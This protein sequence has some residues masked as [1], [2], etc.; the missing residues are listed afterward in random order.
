MKKSILLIITVL[1]LLIG[2]FYTL[3]AY[4]C[5]H[6]YYGWGPFTSCSDGQGKGLNLLGIGAN[7]GLVFWAMLTTLLPVGY[8]YFAKRISLNKLVWLFVGGATLYIVGFTMI[9]DALISPGALI[10]IFN[11]IVIFALLLFFLVSMTTLGNFVFKKLTWHAW[12]SMHDVFLQFTVGLIGFCVLNVLLLMLNVY[13]GIVIR[14]QV[15]ALAYLLWKK[16]SFVRHMLKTTENFVQ[17]V[18]NIL[19]ALPWVSIL[20]YILIIVTCIYIYM[21]LNLSYIP[22][23]TAWDANHAYIFTPRAWA[24][25]NGMYWGASGATSMPYLWYGFLA[26]WFKLAQ[27]VPFWHQLFGISPDALTIIMNFWSGP[28]VLFASGFLLHSFI[29]YL[30]EKKDHTNANTAYTMTILC[31]WRIMMILWLT[32]GMGAFLVFVDNKTDLAVMFLSVIALY[33]GIQFMRSLAHTT[34]NEEIH[35][36]QMHKGRITQY[37]ILAW[38]FFAASI[39]AKPTGMFDMIHFGILFL[40]Q[41]QVVLFGVGA[42]IFILWLLWKTQLLLIS[43]FLT[44]VQSTYLLVIGAIITA[45]WIFLSLKK[46]SYRHYLRYFLIWVTTIVASLVLYK[47]PYTI[48]QQIKMDGHVSIPQ[49][50]RTIV[51][52]Y[53]TDEKLSPASENTTHT[54]SL[55]VLLAATASMETLQA[56]DAA[57]TAALA[58]D[59]SE[60]STTW[61]QTMSTGITTTAM[62]VQILSKQQCVAQTI[63]TKSLYENT[64]KYKSDGGSE[65]LGRYVGY[66]WKG[67]KSI[68]VIWRLPQGC[69]SIY[70]D[71]Q[72]LCTNYD[73]VKK[74]DFTEI[75]KLLA[76]LPQNDR[77]NTWIQKWKEIWDDAFARQTLVKEIT[78]YVESNAIL[79]TGETTNVPYKLL[80]PLNVTFN[81]SLQNLS[82][83]YTDIGIIW[84]LGLWLVILGLVYGLVTRKKKLISISVITL[85]AWATWWVIASGIIWYSLGLIVWT[86][87][88]TIAYFYYVFQERTEKNVLHT[89]LLYMTASLFVLWALIQLLLNLVRISSQGGGGPFVRYKSNVWQISVVD[90]ELQPQTKNVIGYGAKEVLD[91]QFPHYN[92]FLNKVN[93]RAEWEGVII[94]GTY[95]QYFVNNQRNVVADGFLTLFWENLSDN[96][97]CNTYLRLKDQKTK[98]I[99]IDPNIA[100]VVMGGGNSTLLDRFLWVVWDNGRIAQ[101]GTLTMLQSLVRNNYLSLFSTNNIVTKYAFTATDDQLSTLLKIPVG[102]QLLVE[103]AKMSSARYFPNSQAYA[104]AAADLFVSRM[105]TYEAMQDIADI[106]GKEIRA[107]KIIPIARRLAGGVKQEEYAEVQASMSDLTNDE[108]FVVQQ[109]VSILQA[110]T[111]NPTQFRQYVNS[112]I[113]QS[114]N[115]WSQI[116]VLTVE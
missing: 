114:I 28:L 78:T 30:Q 62:P 105:R 74:W 108:K 16:Q 113:S 107:D 33:V 81:W 98:Y 91:L 60:K 37:A 44:P 27:S 9:K 3:D 58:A 24:I 12:D 50:L 56:A 65:D 26:F 49:T 89:V 71:A 40:L 104:A 84:L 36:I 59:T 15:V 35:D 45:I 70:T 110:Q 106:I 8:M 93:A 73:V 64:R 25:N 55:W 39:L 21:G 17:N 63:D 82:S 66:G 100:S 53:N 103:R 5:S 77:I 92:T 20:Y 79:R 94:A 72:A 111:Q 75:M 1:L 4:L 54:Q 32:S 76:T 96:N 41:W 47:W 109:F 14:G 80:I 90:E 38:L 7:R 13:F 48:I 67:F 11:L 116:I 97:I 115:N 18:H 52:W 51:L 95:A 68:A 2:W 86:I 88:G 46:Y 85:G 34:T 43:Q 112:L 42:Y 57:D 101:Y 22:Y 102:E 61:M 83:Y 23:P 19:S 6:L 99:A 10:L 69:Y 29:E 31:V 87:L